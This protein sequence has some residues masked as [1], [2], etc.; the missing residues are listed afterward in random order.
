MKNLKFMEVTANTSK[1]IGRNN[2]VTVQFGNVAKTDGNIITL[3]K[4]Q[5]LGNISQQEQ[6]V[7]QG[8]R[9]HET[10]HVLCTGMNDPKVKEEIRELNAQE[11]ETLNGLED[12][13]IERCG[14][15][16]YVGMKANIQAMN[17]KIFGSIKEDLNKRNANPEETFAPIDYALLLLSGKVRRNA[18][19]DQD[20]S[21]EVYDNAS[22]NWKDLVAKWE[23]IIE[24]IP[25]GWDG[26]TIDQSLATKGIQQIIGKVPNFIIDVEKVNSKEQKQKEEQQ[27][28][29]DNKKTKNNT[30]GS[31]QLSLEGQSNSNQSSSSSSK[32]DSQPSSGSSSSPSKLDK[33]Q[34]M[35]EAL[36]EI[37]DKTSEETGDDRKANQT[38]KSNSFADNWVL[39]SIPKVAIAPQ[40]DAVKMFDHFIADSRQDV[41]VTKRGLELALQAKQ[42]VDMVG[43]FRNGKLDNRRLTSAINGDNYVYRRR[44][45]GKDIDTSVSILV[46][47]SGSMQD[48]IDDN[49]RNTKISDNDSRAIVASRVSYILCKACESVGC[50]TEVIGFPG[51]GIYR[52]ELFDNPESLSGGVSLLNLDSKNTYYA[53]GSLEI[54]ES[55]VT[56]T[57]AG[58]YPIKGT[59]YLLKERGERV[60]N[61]WPR[62]GFGL[63]FPLS[64]GGTPIAEWIE[65]CLSR[66]QSYQ[67]KKRL[68]IV[69]TDG[70]IAYGDARWIRS[71]RKFA[72]KEK[73]HVLGVGIGEALT[74]E[75]NLAFGNCVVAKDK[76]SFSNKLISKV[77]KI[78]S[79]DK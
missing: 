11:F 45:E 67:E 41:M 30:D 24:D 66:I 76:D 8:Y 7:F 75:L 16:A 65:V 38:R 44:G 28:Q 33:D 25:T 69:I 60:D 5:A 10:L 13:R 22:Q 62:C 27:N 43:G 68:L 77:A 48:G 61:P 47:L 72:D 21:M 78:I 74:S 1:A 51:E 23:K 53:H 34:L 32:T 70:D 57:T 39:T 50:K 2:N 58:N 56:A 37:I 36:Q 9:D 29:Q 12:I 20:F 59:A 15:Q 54:K 71:M 26:T 73:I 52:D 6:M 40:Q 49:H 18:G 79:E 55:F 4:L 31:L 35:Q 42:N 19:Y 64:C 3:P 46:D 63:A 14:A 17:Q